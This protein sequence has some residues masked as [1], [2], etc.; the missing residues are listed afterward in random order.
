MISIIKSKGCV[1]MFLV[2]FSIKTDDDFKN[3]SKF[4]ISIH[5]NFEYAFEAVKENLNFSISELFE[6]EDNKYYH[7]SIEIKVADFLSYYDDFLEKVNEGVDSFTCPKTDAYFDKNEKEFI[8][9]DS[10]GN[11]GL[12]V[13]IQEVRSVKG[14]IFEK[15]L[16]VKK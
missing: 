9:F 11:W 15:G 1:P 2:E 13:S 7:S 8:I 6:N 12:E 4:N 14:D 3:P 16:F 10:Y 5:S